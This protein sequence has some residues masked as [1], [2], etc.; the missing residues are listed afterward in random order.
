[1]RQAANLTEPAPL[2]K[3][4]PDSDKWFA[5]VDSLILINLLC[6]ICFSL[7]GKTKT[8]SASTPTA[9]AQRREPS[10]CFP[11]PAPAGFAPPW[12]PGTD[13]RNPA[14]RAGTGSA[15]L[16]TAR[17]N[18]TRCH[19]EQ[20]SLSTHADCELFRGKVPSPQFDHDCT[21][22]DSSSLLK[23]LI[24]YSRLSQHKDTPCKRCLPSPKSPISS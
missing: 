8:C 17:E 7:E 14:R 19:P 9:C 20:T 13:S 24:F 1:M 11:S 3:P 21:N 22:I 12:E 10:L 18:K 2:F 6:Q 15:R 5:S 4:G 16:P 23:R